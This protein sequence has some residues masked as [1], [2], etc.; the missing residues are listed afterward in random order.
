MAVVGFGL[1]KDIKNQ[2]KA[3]LKDSGNF[4]CES[5]IVTTLEYF[6]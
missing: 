5:L 3:V 6:S 1:S 2:L 4:K